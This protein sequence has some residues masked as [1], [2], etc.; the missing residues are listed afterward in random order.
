VDFDPVRAK[1][2]GR[3]TG[4]PPDLAA[5][6]PD[7][8]VES[9]VGEISEG[10][11]VGTVADYAAVSSGKRPDVRYPEI[12]DKASV[13]LWGGNGPMAYVPHALIEYPILLTGRVGTLGSVFR[14]VSPCWPSDNTLVVSARTA[15]S[16]EYLFLQLKRIDF[17]ALNRGSTQPLLLTQ[18]DLKL[19]PIL[20]PP[21]AILEHFHEIAEELYGRVDA[22]ESESRTLA[23]L[24]DTLLPKLLSGEV[25]V[26]GLDHEGAK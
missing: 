26:G 10:W 7:R 8:L 6:F 20:L 1:M 13:P 23:A 17:S 19:Q 3:D 5:L 22:S 25:R 18:T 14:I 9:E 15:R 12:S 21:T 4:L 24:R 16:F 11:E 2:E